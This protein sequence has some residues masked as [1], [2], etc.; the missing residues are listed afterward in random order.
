MIAPPGW[1]CQ[2]E[3]PPGSTVIFAMATSVPTFS[4]IFACDVLVP[5]ARGKF[6]SP[7]GGVAALGPA[8]AAVTAPASPTLTSAH[9][10]DRFMAFSF[11]FRVSHESSVLGGARAVERAV[12]H[13]RRDAGTLPGDPR[14]A[15][16]HTGLPPAS[17]HEGV[18]PHAVT[19]GHSLWLL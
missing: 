12:A 1:E 13:G 4:R 5:L 11:A 17:P 18:P 15:I 6:V 14:T 8:V 16:A 3:T 2:P 9:R 10:T 7:D 19:T